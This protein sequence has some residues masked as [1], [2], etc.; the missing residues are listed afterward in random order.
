M[1]KN[2]LLLIF[3]FLSIY[4]FAQRMTL[5]E[6][7][8][9]SKNNIRLFPKYGYAKKTAGQLQADQEFVTATMKGF[10]T[11]R[12]ASEHLVELGFKYL[13][14][15][16]KIAMYRF[17][18][19]FLLDSTNVDIY[20]GFGAVYLTLEDYQS[21]KKQYEAGLHINPKSTHLLTDYGT[22]FMSQFA[23]L[24]DLNKQE[25]A[26]ELNNAL[27]CFKKSYALD[28]KDQNTL[29]KFSACYL[30]K[31]DCINARRYYNECMALGGK[32][33]TVEFTNALNKACKK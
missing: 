3:S 14:S 5:N 1:K 30:R 18:Q 24:E 28:P 17:N 20:W 27:N 6:W 29:F 7:N 22:Y 32:P 26:K 11:K 19:A 31:G 9:E 33:I 12:K 10:S 16:I 2:M 4:S 21:A 13:Y 15:D 23:L 8:E 25:A